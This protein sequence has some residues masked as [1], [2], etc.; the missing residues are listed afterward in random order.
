MKTKARRKIFPHEAKALIFD[1]SPGGEYIACVLGTPRTA[2]GAAAG[3]STD[4]L[5]IGRPDAGAEEWW[6]VPGSEKLAKTELGSLIEQLRATR[7]AWTANSQSF[8]YVTYH[9]SVSQKN[10]DE[11]RLW[12]GR[13]D[14]RHVEEIARKPDRIRDLHWSPGGEFLGFVSGSSEPA[15]VAMAVASPIA[16]PMPTLHTWSRAGGVS[17]PLSNRPVRRFAGWS[18]AGDHLAYVVPGNVLGANGPLWAFL[19]V[20]DPRSRDAVLTANADEVAQGTARE[21]F[22]GLRVTFPHWSTASSDELLSLW[23]TFT[24]SHRSVLSQFLGGGLRSGDPAAVLDAHTGLVKWMAVS[25]FEEAQIGHY[26]QIKHAYDE[27]WRR[28]ERSQ[29]AGPNTG[30]ISGPEPKSPREWLARLLSPAGIAVF[31][32][33]CLAKLNRHAEAHA[34]LESFRKAYPPPLPAS[35]TNG[36]EKTPAPSNFP[37]INPGFAT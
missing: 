5:W 25:P 31:Q 6:H 30:S 10:P 20:P 24:P 18:T 22:S 15:P 32:Y 2:T 4:G 34:K 8:A 17:G 19:I 36:A 14:G 16:N 21:V 12:I 37:S 28:Y 13:L 35:A 11:T 23:C 3:A 1:W 7:P 33:H 27:A 29:A 9:G 26:E